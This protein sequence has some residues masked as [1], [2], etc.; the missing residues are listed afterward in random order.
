MW[1]GSKK[2]EIKADEKQLKEIRIKANK[3][4]NILQGVDHSD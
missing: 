3:G 2:I 1:C 4:P